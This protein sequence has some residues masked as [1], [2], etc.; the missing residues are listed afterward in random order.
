MTPLDVLDPTLEHDDIEYTG[1]EVSELSPTPRKSLF[2]MSSEDLRAAEQAWLHRV[3]SL[4]VPSIYAAIPA[5]LLDEATPGTRQDSSSSAKPSLLTREEPDKS[6]DLS[7][8]PTDLQQQTIKAYRESADTA[9]PTQEEQ[10]PSQDPSEQQGSGLAKR[11]SMSLRQRFSLFRTALDYSS[12]VPGLSPSDALSPTQRPA[13]PGLSADEGAPAASIAKVYAVEQ[14]GEAAEPDL[15][16]PRTPWMKLKAIRRPSAAWRQVP[17]MPELPA[18]APQSSTQEADSQQPAASASVQGPAD[19][20]NLS[21]DT[22]DEASAAKQEPHSEPMAP[23]GPQVPQTAAGQRAVDANRGGRK[24][25]TPRNLQSAKSGAS[26]L[27]QEP[28]LD[29]LKGSPDSIDSLESS[30]PAREWVSEEHELRRYPSAGHHSLASA[31]PSALDRLSHPAYQ[32]Q[33]ELAS[34]SSRGTSRRDAKPK[35]LLRGRS[36]EECG[37]NMYERALAAQRSRDAR[38]DIIDIICM[39]TRCACEL[40]EGNQSWSALGMQRSHYLCK[41]VTMQASALRSQYLCMR[42]AE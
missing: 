14:S 36:P 38:C 16:V 41:L 5:A 42:G 7:V 1:L 9:R 40:H 33:R 22:P 21:S 18:Q 3:N 6:S 30:M 35:Q 20:A 19:S 2:E 13:A 23:S 28:S 17:Q 24:T 8:K 26:R 27:P 25:G 31:G 39:L 34:G 29:P 12:P 11:T 15:S 32:T 10:R 4:R 37:V